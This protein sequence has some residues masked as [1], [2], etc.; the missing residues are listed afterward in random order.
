[1]ELV[2]I[3]DQRRAILSSVE[4]VR[5]TLIYGVALVVLDLAPLSRQIH[6]QRALAWGFLVCWR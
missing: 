2:I 6:G 3:S 5:I 1:V 4:A